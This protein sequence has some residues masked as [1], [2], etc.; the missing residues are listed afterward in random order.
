MNRRI[1]GVFAGAVLATVGWSTASGWESGR[2]GQ[3]AFRPVPS[4]HREASDVGDDLRIV[5][6]EPRDDGL[7]VSGWVSPGPSPRV[8]LATGGAGRVSEGGRRVGMS[9]RV[10]SLMGGESGDFVVR[11]PWATEGSLFA[12]SGDPS[13]VASPH[14]PVVGCP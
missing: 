10:L 3:I 13:G 4:I 8:I 12:L 1:L 5:G 11:L 14:G 2:A 9:Y 7:V 6:C